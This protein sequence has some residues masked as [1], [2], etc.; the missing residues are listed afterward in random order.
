MSVVCHIVPDFHPDRPG[1]PGS[2]RPASRA[3]GLLVYALGFAL[4]CHLFVVLLEELVLR[5]KFSARYE[6]YCRA[7]HRCLPSMAQ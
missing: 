7:V 1:H 5:R 3:A 4:C 2:L 6:A